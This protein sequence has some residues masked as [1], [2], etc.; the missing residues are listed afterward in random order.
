[1]RIPE[2]LTRGKVMS[3]WN[4]KLKPPESMMVLTGQASINPETSFQVSE[5][6]MWVTAGVSILSP[7]VSRAASD[8]QESGEDATR[9]D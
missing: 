5:R 9:N 6:R 4:G 2:P 7:G 1:M 8:D 3:G